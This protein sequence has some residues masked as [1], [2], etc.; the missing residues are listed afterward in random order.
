M[1]FCWN[2]EIL[3]LAFAVHVNFTLPTESAL[4][5]RLTTHKSR[6]SCCCLWCEQKGKHKQKQGQILASNIFLYD[7]SK[8]NVLP[9]L[10]SGRVCVDK[11]LQFRL[12]III[13]DIIAIGRMKCQWVQRNA[14]DGLR[15][16]RPGISESSINANE[17][18]SGPGKGAEDGTF[19]TGLAQ[20]T[21]KR[22]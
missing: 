20:L 21:S 7:F 6:Y 1:A 15:V 9:R 16:Q 12:G 11:R 10:Y 5:S 8:A 4:I 19:E 22:P 14:L 3:N 17:K 18:P 13:I 2:V